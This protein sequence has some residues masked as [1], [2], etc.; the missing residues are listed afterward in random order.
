MFK[1]RMEFLE[2]SQGDEAGSLAHYVQ[3]FNM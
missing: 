1:D 2:F 3:K